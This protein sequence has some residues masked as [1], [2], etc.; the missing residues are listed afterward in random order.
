MRIGVITGSPG[1]RQFEATWAFIEGL[2]RH[3]ITPV[4]LDS[5]QPNGVDLVAMWAFKRPNILGPWKN[6]VFRILVLE[7]GYIGDRSEWCSLGYDGLNG[8][9]TFYTAEAPG[10]RLAK[11]FPDLLKPWHHD[12]E[13][14]ALIMGQA[15]G[16]AS[17]RGLNVSSWATDCAATLIDHG[18]R[19][20][21]RP[22]PVRAPE[23]RVKNAEYTTGTLADALAGAAFVVTYNSNS[24]VDAACAG[25]PVIALDRG[26]M[27]RPVASHALTAP[28]V[29]PDRQR[30]AERLAYS[31]WSNE[32]LSNGTAWEWAKRGLESPPGSDNVAEL[33]TGRRQIKPGTATESQP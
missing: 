2:R 29:M 21:F 11:H 26:S 6:K 17:L 7:N 14:Y 1:G 20:K 31:Q 24:G 30:W 28:L 8:N 33:A 3:G 15:P 9:A 32:E 25:V 12:R 10:D 4:E 18:W 27:A 13:G 23:R 5:S 16:D 22:H 19:V